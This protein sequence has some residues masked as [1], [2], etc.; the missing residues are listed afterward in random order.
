MKASTGLNPKANNPAAQK[1]VVI[2]P[3]CGWLLT[4]GHIFFEEHLKEPVLEVQWALGWMLVEAFKQRRHEEKPQPS[5]APE[6]PVSRKRGLSWVSRPAETKSPAEALP[7]V[8]SVH[9]DEE[10]IA[11]AS[12]LTQFFA[13]LPKIPGKHGAPMLSLALESVAE[14]G[15]WRRGVLL[16]SNEDGQT[17][18]LRN[19]SWPELFAFV[20]ERLPIEMRFRLWRCSLQI[21]VSSPALAPLAEIPFALA[22]AAAE[23]PPGAPELLAEALEL[24]VS[25][26]LS[27]AT[28][29]QKACSVENLDQKL[30]PSEYIPGQVQSIEPNAKKLPPAIGIPSDLA[31]PRLLLAPAETSV[32]READALAV[33]AQRRQELAALGV[34]IEECCL[35]AASFLAS[36]DVL[37]FCNGAGWSADSGLAVYRDVAKVPAYRNRDL[38]YYDICRMNWLH[39]EPEL[40]WGFWG[41]CFNDY[42]RTAPHIGYQIVRH[43]TDCLFRETDVARS[44]REGIHDR[45]ISAIEENGADDSPYPYEVQG[46]ADAFMIYTSNVDAHHYDWFRAAE[47]REVHGNTE[48]YQCAGEEREPGRARSKREPCKGVWR[49]PKT[50]HFVVDCETMLAPKAPEDLGDS[51]RVVTN[52]WA[53][54]EG[55]GAAQPRIGRVRGTERQYTLRYMHEVST[56]VSDAAR[57]FATNHPVCQ[58]CGGPARPSILMFG[59]HNFQDLGAQQDRYDRWEAA[60][61]SL[62][63]SR[64]YTADPLRVVILE[65]GAG[66]NVRTIREA[67]EHYLLEWLKEGADAKLLRVNPDFP[68]P[69]HS[70]LEDDGGLAGHVIS[71]MGRGLQCVQMMDHFIGP[72]S[73]GRPPVPDSL[74]PPPPPSS[75]PPSRPSGPPSDAPPPAPSS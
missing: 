14:S 51:D 12:R 43:W 42:R 30:M 75:A 55:D 34:D 44:I 67:S 48:L 33:E 25:A 41:Q 45:E 15:L 8:E 21:C 74:P 11:M 32:S 29:A 6:P 37:L 7:E 27:S 23:A 38:T 28:D 59:D 62:I 10:A 61:R 4:L 17:R 72:A 53:S 2:E 3:L 24:G 60:V 66:D 18:W 49:A 40:F 22:S 50:Y 19:F 35:H 54:D 46:Q 26:V 69:D 31:T 58:K 1:Q 52:H 20:H 64:A 16:P 47:I 65:V 73:F 63:K 71:M 39:D 36:A 13:L 68:L 56:D 5:A 70:N 9:N 57:G